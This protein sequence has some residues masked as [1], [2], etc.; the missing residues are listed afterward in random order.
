VTPR[1]CQRCLDLGHGCAATHETEDVEPICVFCLDDVPCPVQRKL[2]RSGSD[3]EALTT[4]KP[5]AAAAVKP[6]K[7]FEEEPMLETTL[8][9]ANGAAA[10][11]AT[12]MCSRP[13]CTTELGP[14]NKS[15][16]CS[17][18][19]HYGEA[20]KNQAKSAGNGHAAASSAGANGTHTGPLIVAPRAAS[21]SEGANGRSERVETVPDRAGDFREDRLDKLILSL[22]FA[23][24]A[25]IAAAWL[26]GSL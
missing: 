7:Q 13:G 16:R 6:A 19:F 15:G 21:G 8:G 11:V 12:K 18:H 25:K 5:A 20:G 26:R 1:Q 14:K 3:H 22:P 24:K 9:K 4:E 23:D 10:A 17:S 2:Q